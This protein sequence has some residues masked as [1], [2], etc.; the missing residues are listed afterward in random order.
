MVLARLRHQLLG[1]LGVRR[2][3]QRQRPAHAGAGGQQATSGDTLL[4]AFTPGWAGTHALGEWQGVGEARAAPPA[5]PASGANQRTAANKQRGGPH[6]SM[7]FSASTV[8]VG[9]SASPPP[10]PT[11]SSML[12][13]LR[14][15]LCRPGPE[16]SEKES[17]LAATEP[18]EDQS[19]PGVHRAEKASCRPTRSGASPGGGRF[20]VVCLRGGGRGCRSMWR[21]AG[22]RC[23]APRPRRRRGRLRPRTAGPA[24]GSGKWQPA[25]QQQQQQ[26]Q[27]K[28]HRHSSSSRRQHLTWPGLRC[29]ARRR[30]RAGWAGGG[31]QSRLL[32][33][34]AAPPPHQS[35]PG[36]GA[37]CS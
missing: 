29:H 8:G 12:A 17:S 34:C 33:R 36:G 20:R 16:G 3:A 13:S 28:Q 35:R 27:T 24:T 21:R 7:S 30:A 9:G 18:G 15:M 32:T 31:S 25:T 26:Q 23:A 10:P 14:P 37:A 22:E 2:G 4:S 19:A 6:L 11:S 5:F 1:I